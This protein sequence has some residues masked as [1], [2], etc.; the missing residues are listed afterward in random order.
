MMIM[1]IKTFIDTFV[2][3]LYNVDNI[4]MKIEP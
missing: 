4:E 2:V 3:A 1:M